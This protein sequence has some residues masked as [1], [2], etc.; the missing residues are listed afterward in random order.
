MSMEIV[1]L[2]NLFAIEEMDRTY[3]D[4]KV[5]IK[6]SVDQASLRWLTSKFGGNA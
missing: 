2:K 6:L 5:I 3:R 1:K 4:F